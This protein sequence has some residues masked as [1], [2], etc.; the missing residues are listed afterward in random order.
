MEKV[1]YFIFKKLVRVSVIVNVRFEKCV[2]VFRLV[3]C[4]GVLW[5]KCKIVRVIIDYII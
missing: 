4:Y 3:V 5:I 1:S 2:E